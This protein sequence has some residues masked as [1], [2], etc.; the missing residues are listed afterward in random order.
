MKTVLVLMLIALEVV[1]MDRYQKVDGRNRRQAVPP[2]EKREGT[3]HGDVVNVVAS[4]FRVRPTLAEACKT[5]VYQARISL[6]QHVRTQTQL[7]H[8][9]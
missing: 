5:R 2:A 9:T 1:A 3:G 6:Q 4:S 7:F 8:Y